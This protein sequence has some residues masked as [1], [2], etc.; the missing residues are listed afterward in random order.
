MVNWKDL[1]LVVFPRRHSEIKKIK[2][3]RISKSRTAISK[4]DI[5]NWCEEIDTFHK[6]KD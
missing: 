1:C 6:E 3:K 2:E 5:E 4:A